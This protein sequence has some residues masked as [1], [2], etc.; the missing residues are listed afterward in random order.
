M[1]MTGEF[2]DPVDPNFY[3]YLAASLM[4]VTSIALAAGMTLGYL[5]L[6][7]MKLKIKLELGTEDEKAAVEAILV[8]LKDRHLLLCTLLGKCFA[9]L[10]TLLQGNALTICMIV[11]AV[12]NVIAAETLPIFMDSL[13]PPWFAIILSVTAVLLCGEVLPAA[14]FT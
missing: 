1:S 6:D 12:F 7:V 11:M 2:I 4:C 3:E 8:L 14:I 9:D 10:L 5:S 13:V